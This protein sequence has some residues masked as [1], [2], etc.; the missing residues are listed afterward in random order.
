MRRK[1]RA[2]LIGAGVMGKNHARVYNVLPSTELVA[3]ADID[4]LALEQVVQEYSVHGYESYVDMLAQEHPDIVSIVVPTRLHRQVTIDA[5]ESGSNV[6]VEKPIASTIA[7]AED[8]INVARRSGLKLMVGHIERF[9]PAVVTLKSA[10][11]K[12]EVISINITRVGPL[13]P[14][15]KDVG[16]IIDLGSHDIDLIHFL[17]DTEFEEVHAVSSI[18]KARH[19]DTA[20]LIFRMRNGILAQITTNWLTPYKAREIVVWTRKRQFHA[21]LMTQQLT[22]Y[23]N[24]DLVS[25]AFQ[26]KHWSVPHA[27]P[28]QLELAAFA[29][30]IVTGSPPPVTGEDGLAALTVAHQCLDST[31]HSTK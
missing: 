12:D 15:V 22:E 18:S 25:G 21:N 19:E 10:L 2:A 28:L 30:A 13:P 27:E 5:L 3:V 9:N 23:S 4:V 24:Y 16:V 11:D 17:S 14:R 20:L 8:M 29:E 6:L 31:S 26:V 7:E 1:L